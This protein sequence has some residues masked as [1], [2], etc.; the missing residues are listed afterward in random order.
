MGHVTFKN[1]VHNGIKNNTPH[2]KCNRN[3]NLLWI[4]PKIKRLIK[5][6]DRL[7]I[8]WKKV[9]SSGQV[10][11]THCLDKKMR[12]LKKEILKESSRA[13]W[14]HVETIISPMEED[15]NENSGMKRFWSF[16]KHE[17]TDHVG[18]PTLKTVDGREISDPVG[19]ANILNSH[20]H[21][22]FTRET[23]NC[24]IPSMPTNYPVTQDISITREGVNRLIKNIKV[25][26]APVPYSI[27]PRVMKE[28]S[29]PVSSI[30]TTIYRK[31]YETGKIPCDWKRAHVTP[32]FKKG[33]KQDTNN[34]RPISLTCISCKLLEHII[35]SQVPS[36]DTPTKTT[37]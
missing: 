33:S 36:C 25:H 19:K 30:L 15:E 32:I 3:N 7:D 27:T 34:Y 5:R 14:E 16:I 24:D 18:V 13:Y 26:K 12:N 20:F 23:G 10:A 29:E 35:A 37:K 4:T 9:K 11:I 6:R 31:S 8:K 1:D 22:S 17:K 28:L 2:K 21:S